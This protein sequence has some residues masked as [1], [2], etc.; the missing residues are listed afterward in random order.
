MEQAPVLAAYG[1][2]YAYGDLDVLNEISLELDRH[3][4][5][6]LLGPNGSGKSTLLKILAGILP[7]RGGSG[8][9]HV[10]F[11]GRDLSLLKSSE[12]AQSV[13]YVASD[14]RAEFPL[15]A[16][17]AV[18]M[19]RSCLSR[20]LLSRFSSHDEDAVHAAMEQCYCWGLRSR[21]LHTLSGGERQLVILAR[22][23][24]Q[25]A[26]V[27]LL[28]EALSK[29][30]LNHQA[31]VGRLLRSLAQEGY[32]IILVSHDVNLGTEWADTCL[33]LNKGRTVAHGPVRE[34]LIEDRIRS[35]YPGAEL[36][37][38]ANPVTGMPKVFFA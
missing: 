1:V 8:S 4:I 29:M 13:A 14:L 7:I 28:D 36:I 5:L 24:A 34:V 15:T 31:L 33:L 38:G 37:V 10:N 19:G 12:R 17:E 21:D 32:A 11:A 22:A 18:M 30:D 2:T 6:A 25:G 9:G 3:E 26:R 35:L 20:S 16:F 23:I 27:L